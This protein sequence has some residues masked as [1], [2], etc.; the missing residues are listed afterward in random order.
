M[1]LEKKKPLSL[2]KCKKNAWDAFSK[3]VRL[4]DA[5]KTTGDKDWVICVTCGRRL[6]AFGVGCAQAG[7]LIPGRGN[8]VL[9][10]ERFVN[11]QC[12]HCNYDLKGNWVPYRRKMVEEHGKE[13]VEEAE[14][15]HG[16][17]Q[18]ITA[19]QWLE[20]AE[21]YKKKYEELNSNN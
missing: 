21:L 2:T 1:K 5:I 18:K 8:S 13:S 9:V 19:I 4:R 7:H 14:S 3:Y 17:V 6:P 20:L 11:A 12:Y 15:K 10:D 16:K